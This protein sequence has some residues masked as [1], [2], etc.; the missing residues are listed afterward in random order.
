MGN[1][2]Y[3]DIKNFMKFYSAIHINIANIFLTEK[4]YFETYILSK[5]Y[6]N[7]M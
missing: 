4:Q 6:N 3:T 2:V 7:I 5:Y 1:I